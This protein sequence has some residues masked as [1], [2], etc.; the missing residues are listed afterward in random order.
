MSSFLKWLL[1]RLTR[2]A[3]PVDGVQCSD[4][5]NVP[6]DLNNPAAGPERRQPTAPEFDAPEFPRNGANFR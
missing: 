3:V 4:L 2:G 1:G 5:S 6:H